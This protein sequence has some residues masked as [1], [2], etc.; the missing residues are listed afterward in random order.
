M[1]AKASNLARNQLATLVKVNPLKNN[2]SSSST[3]LS[4]VNEDAPA[5]YN[6]GRSFFI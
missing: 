3:V 1:L 2:F 4:K 6:F 5:G